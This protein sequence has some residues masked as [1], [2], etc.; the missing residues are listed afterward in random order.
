MQT[1]PLPLLSS[2]SWTETSAEPK[3]SSVC[4]QLLFIA[5]VLTP[6]G[7]SQMPVPENAVGVVEPKLEPNA[8]TDQSLE[9]HQLPSTNTATWTIKNGST[10]PS[11]TL[12]VGAAPLSETSAEPKPSSA[13]HQLIFHATLLTPNG[14]TPTTTVSADGCAHNECD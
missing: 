14:H 6:H 4:H 13:C 10:P 1:K 9:C 7:R 8:G 2:S 12:A 3:P 5:T 11:T